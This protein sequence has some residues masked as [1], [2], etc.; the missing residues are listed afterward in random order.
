MAHDN[1]NHNLFQNEYG[2]W[3]FQAKAKGK[4]I[5]FTLNTKS[6]IKAREL[7]NQHLTD[8][9][10]YGG[11]LKP[12]QKP[13]ED[14]AGTQPFGE[15][16]QRWARI[17]ETKIAKSTMKNYRKAMNTHVLPAFGNKPI[18]SIT[19]GDIE[20]FIADLK[21]VTGKT[22]VNI[23]TPFKGVMKEA[24][25]DGLIPEN[26]MARV[27]SIATKKA[28]IH[29]LSLEEISVFLDTVDPH[30]KPFFTVSFFTGARISELA[31]LT[32][33]RVDFNNKVL[34]IREAL[35][36][37]E[38]KV[39]KTQSSIRDIKINKFVVDALREQRKLTWGKSEY[40][41]LNK[42]GR[43][44]NAHTINGKVFKPTLEKAG[45]DTNRS[46]KDTRGTFITNALDLNE[47]MSFV[48]R[49]VGHTTTKMI[50]NHYYN[51]IPSDDEGDKLEDAFEKSTRVV[52]KLRK[53]GF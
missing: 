45:L 29:P 40:V 37:G 8:I 32:W 17:K 7:R 19:R 28:E 3:Y 43:P 18:G 13:V 16:A 6:V 47:K 22:K 41:F 24:W 1:I 15:V 31:A 39:P 14:T 38:T 33:P 26:P 11:I 46:C 30:F 51:H 50:I 35:V 52:P 34:S 10:L 4:K 20:D 53:T 5:K 12:E 2:V 48:Q 36:Y 49:Q 44:L 21:G 9:R 25:K 27:D 23:M 42:A